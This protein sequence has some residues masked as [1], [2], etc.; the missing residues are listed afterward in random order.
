MSQINLDSSPYFDDFD[1]EKDFYKVLFKPGF[2]VQARELTTLQSILQNQISSFGEHFFKEGSMVIPGSIGYNPQYTAVIVKPQQGGIDVSLYLDKLVGKTVRGDVTG[3]RG[4]VI[5]YLLPPQEGVEDATLFVSYI[6]SGD[7]ES[8]AVFASDEALI[9]EQPITYGNTTITDGSFCAT[10]VSTDATAVG[11]ACKISSGVYFV[12]STFVQVAEDSIILEPYTNTPT[13]RVGLQ[14]NEQIVTAGQDETLYDNAKGFNNFSA[15]GADRLKIN[16]T[17]IKKPVTDYNDDDFIELLRVDNGEVKKLE[18]QAEYNVILDYIAQRT[19]D[20]SGDYAVSGLGINAE[21]SLNDNLANGGIYT[22]NQKTEQGSDPSDDLAILQI[23]PGKA[24]VRG[25]DIKTSGTFNLDAP[26]ARTTEGVSRSTSPF[27]MGNKYFVNNVI[28]S[29]AIGLDIQDNIIQLYNG[30]LDSSQQP[31]G[32]L[33]GEA[34]PYSYSLEDA[35]YEGPQTSWN[36]FLYDLQ[37]FTKIRF[38][39]D[40]NDVGLNVGDRIQGLSSDATGFIR[41]KDGRNIILTEMSGEFIVGEQISANGTPVSLNTVAADNYTQNQVKS[42]KQ[43]TNTL[44]S[45]N[46]NTDF[47]ADTKLYRRVP[48]GFD[49]ADRCRISDGASGQPRVTCPGRTFYDFNP[50][51]VISYQLPANEDINYAVVEKISQNGFEMIINGV[52]TVPGVCEGT[53]PFNTGKI[54][55]N[56]NLRV[57]ESR[58]RNSKRSS[59][60]SQMEQENIA[61][62]DLTASELYFV[63]QITNK[64][65]N[66]GRLDISR[67]DTGVPDAQFAAFDQE[68]YTIIYSDGVIAPLRG[69]QVKLGAGSETVR[70][71]GLRT[72]ATNVTVIATAIKPSIK[73]KI[74]RHRRSRQVFVDKVGK[75]VETRNGMGTSRFYGMRVEDE[76][77]CLLHPD[78]S[79]VIAVYESTNDTRPTLDK[80]NF[81]NGLQLDTAV[82]RGELIIGQTTGAVARHVVSETPATVEVVYMGQTRFEIGETVLFQESGIETNLQTV[83]PGQYNDITDNFDLD[84]GQRE[85]FYD[86]SRLVRK[87]GISAPTRKL[88]VIYDRFDVPDNDSGDFYTANSY[89]ESVYN[90][91]V[92]LLR[93]GTIRASDTLDF[94]P[95]VI[96]FT[97]TDTSPFTYTSRD[98]AEVGSTVVRVTAPGESMALGYDFYVGRKDRLVLT[99]K[100]EFQLVQGAP[101][102]NPSLPEQQEGAMELAKITFP[103][104]TYNVDDIEIINIDNRRYT[105]RDIG[106]LEDRIE[107]L[108]DLTSLSLLERETES[109]QILDA[110]GLNRFKSGF[111]ADDFKDIDFIKY[112][113][114][115]TN[116]TVNRDEERLQAATQFETIP[117]T[118]KL[119]PNVDTGEVSMDGD[120]K[121]R[122][123]NTTKTGDLITLDYKEIEW[124]TQPLASRQ[125]NL[126]PFSN[127]LYNG[128]VRLFP[129]RYDFVITRDDLGEEIDQLAEERKKRQQE[130]AKAQRERERRRN[131]RERRRERRTTE[132]G[133][134]RNRDTRD[135]RRAEREDRR[136]DRSNRAEA[137][138]NETEKVTGKTLRKD[139]NKFVPERNI[140]FRGEGLRPHTRF[141]PFWDGEAGCEFTP[142]LIEIEMVSGTFQEGDRVRGYTDAD[143]VNRNSIV[144]SAR[145][146]KQNHK[147][148]PNQAPTLTYKTS[149]Y[150]RSKIIPDDYTSSTNILN[151][152]ERS[153]ADLSDQR[154]FGR[155]EKN[156]TLI[157]SK[158]KAVA[159]VSRVRLVADRYGDVLGTFALRDPFEEPVPSFRL[160]TGE[161]TIRLTS[162]ETNERPTLGE[163]IISYG[164]G[165]FR[166]GKNVSKY[167]EDAVK[168]RELTPP[169]PPVIVDRSVTNNFTESVDNGVIRTIEREVILTDDDRTETIR[170]TVERP[171]TDRETSTPR[172]LPTVNPLAQTFRAD[173]TGA[174]LTSVDI[175]MATKSETANLVVQIRPTTLGTPENFLLQ[176]YAEV[177]IAPEDVRTSNDGSRPTNVVFPSP[178]YLEPEI[179]YALVLM[180]PDSDEYSAFIA[181]MGEQNITGDINFKFDD[182][183]LTVK[184]K[185]PQNLAIISQQYVNGS[186]FKSQNGSVW[187]PNQFEDLKFRLY[188][189]SFEEVG[190]VFFDNPD[191]Y[192]TTRLKNN[193]IKTLPR[194]LT[195]GITTTTQTFSLGEA[196]ASTA[197]GDDN[198]ARVIGE[199]DG[200]GGP[201]S[202][203]EAT[204]GK[205]GTGLITGTYNNVEAINLKSNGVGAI[206]NIQTASGV[207][208]AVSVANDGNGYQLGDTL[209]VD[210]EDIGG[211][212]GD[213]SLTVSA[214]GDTDTIFL[215]N[216]Q[217]EDIFDTDKLQRYDRDGGILND[218]GITV[219][220]RS[221]VTDP[222]YDGSVFVLDF[223]NH[224]MHADNNTLT[225]SGVDPDGESTELLEKVGI[226]DNQLTVVDTSIFGSFEGLS[227]STG[228]LIISGEIMEYQVN[229]NVV[230]I[231]QRGVDGSPIRNHRP[232]RRVFKYEASGVSLRRINT[233]HQLPTDQILGYTRDFSSL[234]IQIDRTPRSADQ[235]APFIPQLSF[236]DEQDIGRK[237]VYASQNWQFDAMMPSI[238]MLTPGGGTSIE[239]TVRTVS[240]TSAGGNEASFLDQ[241]N[242]PIVINDIN[243]FSTPRMICS[244]VNE[245]Q[246]LD[247]SPDN[248]SFTIAL[249]MRSTDPNLSPVIDFA[250]TS[251][252][253]SRNSLNKPVTDYADDP[254]TNKLKNDPHSSIYVS[255]KIELENPAT[256]LK[257]LLTAY[258]DESADF[259][260]CY[261]LFGG[262]SEGS[263]TPRWVLF[264]G[265]DNMVDTDG[266]GVGDTIVDP[267]KNS[268][269]PNQ[270][271]SPSIMGAD[272]YFE[273]REY[274]YDIDNLPEFS[275]FQIKV[276]FSGTNEAR[277]PML[278]DIRAIALA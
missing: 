105:M 75:D 70:F 112:D 96:P 257:V 62:V 140:A 253:T 82:K 172:E 24:Y 77:I 263:T 102:S 216:V 193:P 100:G 26:K 178:V 149:P 232:G 136:T 101:A 13:Y 199:V 133:R 203:I 110:D 23:A 11:S 228:Y 76:E 73:S 163:S 127:I 50:G 32:D 53:V 184:E 61:K 137:K 249:T 227:T 147:R 135:E 40:A 88:L 240:G 33:I 4:K 95:R 129:A 209:T 108:E 152:D 109:L 51:D 72:S 248:K 236:V 265:Y 36:L 155:V 153:L 58:L 272:G 176:D 67:T 94:R 48:E 239:S 64:S 215:T 200:I 256:S 78:V 275:T 180:S 247:G 234:P 85:Q 38:N 269:L 145:V 83:T 87:K 154:Y 60:Y 267:S 212:G 165:V 229:N 146:A 45:G 114:Q 237:K 119:P 220:Q 225:I 243:R 68:R 6:D 246:N 89:N 162:S 86:Y 190:T 148:G 196:L 188:K 278:Y 166:S 66:N 125:E 57:T 169:P 20:E 49:R 37:I 179:T 159:T 5:D 186:L 250:E 205:L 270:K 52:A 238:N 211:A 111:F 277:A 97:R 35:A 31:T 46:I 142:K 69:E 81:A 189:A 241:G 121:L 223:A 164:E 98:F 266:D 80:L 21:E 15:P 27:Q 231:S 139:R 130:R 160:K 120:L 244:K 18:E 2:P 235:P 1:S 42:V 156:M 259:R 122:D 131:E 92:P 104:Y 115:D 29:P 271:V 175:F 214:V 12:R 221:E 167:K 151:I 79:A 28:G 171:R 222:M 251:V 41:E 54:E 207:V 254:R 174:F 132:A 30:R 230:T 198:V 208:T 116:V 187:T 252:V 9:T 47:R 226:S 197:Q 16:L 8:T 195:V 91:G 138:A 25:Y 34:R 17:L 59:L 22:E 74:K 39:G 262:A 143:D 44:T 258:R 65:T 274:V 14:I 202:T 128:R 218:D 71:T 217:G 273:Q 144:F 261:R 99:S 123:K 201:I 157:G 158:S 134:Q 84:K 255:N 242:Q 93:D 245:V 19:Y 264:P 191:L 118:V 7:D 181:R 161:K 260:V 117:L 113:Y 126:N 107:T 170:R 55:D 90:E 224:G 219:R 206:L 103:A 56:I 185:I 182:N 194:K 204:E 183:D 10:T 3:V 177:V 276:V 233:Q 268:G 141:Y 106:K 192:N 43:E 210:T 213:V 173:E 168:L 63:S 150:E 124:I